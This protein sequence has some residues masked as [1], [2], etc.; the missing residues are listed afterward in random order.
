ML[1]KPLRS[2]NK[3]EKMKDNRGIWNVFSKFYEFTIRGGLK[4]LQI[5]PPIYTYAPT[6]PSYGALLEKNSEN[7]TQRIEERCINFKYS[8]TLSTNMVIM[9]NARDVGYGDHPI[10]KELWVYLISR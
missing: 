8:K 3:D 4:Q 1:R 5:R 9:G 10:Y 7:S 6:L 2:E